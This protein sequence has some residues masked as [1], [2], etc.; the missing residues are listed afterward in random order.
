MFPSTKYNYLVYEFVGIELPPPP[1]P[2]LLP[3]PSSK[4]Y[5]V[6]IISCKNSLFVIQK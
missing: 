5:Y 1:P 4:Y 3:P 6:P 2:P